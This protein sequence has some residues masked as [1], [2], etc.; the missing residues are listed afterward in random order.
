MPLPSL[1]RAIAI[2]ELHFHDPKPTFT[3][4]NCLIVIIR[5]NMVRA[6]PYPAPAPCPA[7]SSFIE[8]SINVARF[9][10][11]GS[12]RASRFQGSAIAKVVTHYR[13]VR[14][15]HPIKDAGWIDPAIQLVKAPTIIKSRGHDD[16]L[17][18]ARPRP[19]TSV[20]V[21]LEAALAWK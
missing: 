5:M 19:V 3:D 14:I 12:P 17:S 16:C 8:R 21:G 11:V 2:L 9:V 15:A 7:I 13:S 4:K 1:Q 6:L 20:G 10:C 18:L